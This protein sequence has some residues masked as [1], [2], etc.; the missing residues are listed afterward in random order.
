M[1]EFILKTI[2]ILVGLGGFLLASHIYHKKKKKRPLVCPL[3]SN[4][5]TVIN[6]DYSRV[7]GIKLEVLGMVYYA[8]IAIGYGIVNNFSYIAGNLSYVLL[9]LS[10]FAFI[11]SIYLISVQA[12]V[13]KQW[14]AWCLC[15]AFLSTLIFVLSFVVGL[16]L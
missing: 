9:P 1:I 13:L 6:S 7:C 2:V 15:S 12:F 16:V 4:C 8:I 14:C 5:D 10:F 3:K 11:F